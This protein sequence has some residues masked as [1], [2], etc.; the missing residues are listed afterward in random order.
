MKRTFL[1][2]RNALLSSGSVSWGTLALA[3]AVLLLLVRLIAPNFFWYLFTPAFRASEGVA[4]K[5]GSLFSGFN[6]AVTLTQEN[7][8]LENQN[9]LLAA[10]NEAL[11]EKTDSIAGLAIDA[12]SITAGVIARPPESPYDTLVIAAGSAD[13]V[14]MNQEAFGEGEVPLGTVTSVFAH[15]S[16][17]TL[18]S[19]PNVSLLGWVGSKH[20]SI[21]IK[22][23]GGGAISAS[24]PRS[25]SVA[26]GDVV[27]VPG[28]GSLPIGTVVRVDSDSSSPSV[29]LR[30]QPSL[31]LFSVT[32]VTLRDSGTAL[33]SAFAATTTLP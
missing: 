24:V 6:N 22:G 33:E 3:I 17:V 4:Q 26:V 19:A 25:D 13:G 14:T 1:A 9:A 27:S 29:T 16:R 32:W 7:E 11:L 15:F 28:P 2:K 8:A 21:I 31:N 10:Q 30:I 12:Q 20:L 5:T 23:S 18:F